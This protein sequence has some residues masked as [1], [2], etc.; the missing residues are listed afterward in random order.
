MGVHGET[1]LEGRIQY[2]RGSTFLGEGGQN[3]FDDHDGGVADLDTV[4]TSHGLSDLHAIRV[5]WL[6]PLVQ[7]LC[8]GQN[9][10][11]R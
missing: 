11:N 8:N 5:E 6:I 4:N 7:T 1:T 9:Q 10:E 3:K 2:F